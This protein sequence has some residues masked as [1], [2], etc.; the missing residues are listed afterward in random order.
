[1][2]DFFVNA[3]AQEVTQAIELYNEIS[4]FGKRLNVEIW[5]IEPNRY[6]NRYIII[7]R[8]TYRGRNPKIKF[9]KRLH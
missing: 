7:T 6:G 2:A 1:M 5:E 4:D 9:I 8:E 3:Y